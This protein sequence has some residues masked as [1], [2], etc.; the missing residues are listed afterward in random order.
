MMYIKAHSLLIILLLINTSI[1]LPTE[2]T[3]VEAGSISGQSAPQPPTHSPAEPPVDLLAERPT[4]LQL[5]SIVDISTPINNAMRLPG[6]QGSLPSGFEVF[7]MQEQRAIRNTVTKDIWLYDSRDERFKSTT[8]YQSGIRIV[9]NPNVLI[10]T[11]NSIYEFTPSNDFYT[12]ENG[13]R[14]EQKTINPEITPQN[15]LR[16]YN[17]V[18]TAT[19]ETEQVTL[20]L[21]EELDRRAR[22]DQTRQ[23]MSDLQTRASTTRDELSTLRGTDGIQA[24]DVVTELAELEE[25]LRQMEEQISREGIPD[26]ER[27]ELQQRK[28]A[29]E[30][31]FREASSQRSNLLAARNSARGALNAYRNSLEQQ[32]SQETEEDK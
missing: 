11:D 32:Q 12:F 20:P 15:I 31:N 14:S 5:V 1:A 30:Q 26:A 23:R 29:L 28:T 16:L 4:P 22:E 25:Q 8:V 13:R 7:L 6:L 17:D 18:D 19:R 2:T 24:L 21:A 10:L 9:D 27:S 3:D